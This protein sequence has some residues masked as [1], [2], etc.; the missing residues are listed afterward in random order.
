MGAPCLLNAVMPPGPSGIVGNVEAAEKGFRF[1]A[2]KAG[3]GT[4]ECNASLGFSE[5]RVQDVKFRCRRETH[6]AAGR[7]ECLRSKQAFRES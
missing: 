5:R 4:S 6:D 2:K 3:F 7:G 1:V